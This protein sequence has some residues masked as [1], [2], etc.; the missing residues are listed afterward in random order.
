MKFRSLMPGLRLAISRARLATVALV[1][2]FLLGSGVAP[3]LAGENGSYVMQCGCPLEWS[4][5][6][7][8]N[9]IFNED[10]SRDTIALANGTAVLI[11]HEI[12]MV[13]GSLDEMVNDRSASLEDTVEDLDDGAID[14]DPLF[15]VQG[16]TW[17]NAG[18]DTM[19]SLQHVQVWENDFL[20]SIEFV[21]PE[22]D[23][24]DSWDSLEDVLLI[25]AP[26]LGEF[27][28]EEIVGDLL[29]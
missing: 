15:I 13:D 19:V 8:G 16:R 14:S 27:D 21:A 1:C 23:F 25:G 24:V 20:L 6:W 17:T 12:P 3:A 11:F 18:G 26:V 28:A 7:D 4:G 29:G 5:D 10:K 2:A 22:D 9:G